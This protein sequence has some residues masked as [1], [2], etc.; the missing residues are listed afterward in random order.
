MKKKINAHKTRKEW[1]IQK[2]MYQILLAVYNFLVWYI[3]Y[4]TTTK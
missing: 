3:Q 4:T 1:D 2:Y